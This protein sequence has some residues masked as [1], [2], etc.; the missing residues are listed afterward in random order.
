[1]V[2]QLKEKPKEGFFK[3]IKKSPARSLSKGLSKA[4]LG[5]RKSTA[6]ARTMG[7]PSQKTPQVTRSKGPGGLTRLTPSLAQQQAQ[8]DKNMM[9]A[10]NLP[11]AQ[12]ALFIKKAQQAAQRGDP[13]TIRP[14]TKFGK[15]GGLTSI[16]KAPSQK[17]VGARQQQPQIAR[18]TG[19]GGMTRLTKAP[20]QKPN[21][22]SGLSLGQ[23]AK[24][25]KNAYAGAVTKRRKV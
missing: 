15:P 16:T 11:P 20:T 18:S 8:Y 25:A 12:R 3:M 23:L 22:S 1:M 13:S 9:Q 14:G 10:A 4:G 7:K 19:P 21:S 17:P 5:M 6:A 24:E 2:V